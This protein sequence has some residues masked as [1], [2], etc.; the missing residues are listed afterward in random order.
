M[1]ENE[2]IIGKKKKYIEERLEI[3]M[4]VKGK[5]EEQLQNNLIHN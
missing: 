5:G 1:E 3:E 2:I 4:K